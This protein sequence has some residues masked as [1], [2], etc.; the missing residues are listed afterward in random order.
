M[1]RTCPVL[2]CFQAKR[3]QLSLLSIKESC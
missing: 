2:L 3:L 1:G